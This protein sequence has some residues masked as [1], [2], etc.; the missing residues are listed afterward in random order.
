MA[1]DWGSHLCIVQREPRHRLTPKKSN[2]KNVL[3]CVCHCGRHLNRAT[4]PYDR[5]NFDT[6]GERLECAT[7]DLGPDAQTDLAIRY[8]FVL[9]YHSSL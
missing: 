6:M 3:A 8:L 5:S 9:G 2:C 7:N 4:F 1:T